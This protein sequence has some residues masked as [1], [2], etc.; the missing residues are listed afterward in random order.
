MLHIQREGSLI[1]LD[2]RVRI[3]PGPA[4]KKATATKELL[5]NSITA[6]H[7]ALERE[8]EVR[9]ELL[10][11]PGIDAMGDPIALGKPIQYLDWVGHSMGTEGATSWYVYRMEDLTAAEL[12][13]RGVDKE[14]CAA[15]DLTIW[16]EKAVAG[17]ED[18]AFALAIPLLNG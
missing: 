18:E 12:K 1:T 14:L 17:S 3:E 16:R 10:T 11:V 15:E 7:Y 2:G 8:V 9:G 4:L 5:D 6:P 13:V